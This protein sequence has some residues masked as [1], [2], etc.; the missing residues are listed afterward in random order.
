MALET[1]KA[2]YTGKVREIALGSGEKTITIGGETAYPFHTF[3]GKMP[4]KP[5]IALEVV[6]D[7]PDDWPE[8]LTK[9]YGDVM[10]DPVKW[11]KKCVELG[12]DAICLRLESIDPNSKNAPAE[13]AVNTVKKVAEAVTLPLIVWGCG[14]ASKDSE[15]LRKIAEAVENKPLILG[16]VV[17]TNYKTVGAGAIGFGHTVVA[18]TP[19]DVNLA[20]QLNILLEQLG[21]PD[22][23]IVVDPTTGALGYG[24]EY[25]YSVMERD[26]MAALTQGDDKLAYPILNMVGVE[27]WKVKEAKVSAEDAPN[28]GNPEKR[29]IL[30]E[31]ITAMLCLMAGSDLLVLRHP[32]S[33]KL[34]RELIDELIN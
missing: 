11:A 29:G 16:P 32:E 9:I 22:G 18:T 8:A 26:R 7:P 19:I 34:V 27:V 30:M 20:K 6:D 23:K 5:R 10:S 2:N 25:T 14:S 17:D 13:D 33:M 12:A 21:V 1:P 4:H 28:M 31:T 24:L 15:V 3:E